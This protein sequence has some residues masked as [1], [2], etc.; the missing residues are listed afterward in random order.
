MDL[1]ATTSKQSGGEPRG[2]DSGARV[3]Y[4]EVDTGPFLLAGSWASNI[5]P[6]VITPFMLLLSYAVAREILQE[7]SVDSEM[8]D[9]RPPLLHELMRGAHGLCADNRLHATTQGTS[10]K[11]YNITTNYSQNDDPSY[12]AGLAA[13]E[14]LCN[15]TLT[16]P[17]PSNRSSALLP[18]SLNETDGLTNLALA[19]WTYLTLGKGI[20]QVTSNFS[21]VNFS[22][23]DKGEAKGTATRYEVVTHLDGDASHSLFFSPDAAREYDLTDL[24][25]GRNWG[26]DYVANTT[27]MVTECTFATEQCKITKADSG[28]ERAQGWNMSF[29]EMVDGSP[30][31]IPVQAQSNPFDFYAVTAVNSIDFP[32]FQDRNTQSEGGPDNNSLVDVGHG[33]IGFALDCHAT[34]YNVTYS[35]ID[36]SFR[37]FNA[38]KS[39]PQM[40]S[41]IKAPLQVGFGQYSLYQA[42]FLAVIADYPVNVTMAKAFSQT[43]MALASGVFDF[44]NNI[45]QRFR[46]TKTVTKVPKAPFYFLVVTCLLY[47]AFGMV[48]TAVAFYLRRTPEVREQQRRL[49]LEWSPELLEAKVAR[50][51]S[52]LR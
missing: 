39:S 11:I 20:S 21:N 3:Y 41:I 32:S 50:D 51:A 5:A 28:H 13:I 24:G 48:M 52:S 6:F 49:M 19:N 9:V 35:L 43:G 47:S 16:A 18:C 22:S 37:E 1:Q 42:A 44:D 23:S 45:Q 27:S 33:F 17:L 12:K 10:L 25:V 36:G 7:S 26:I 31:N 15:D 4:T 34:I 38:T 14:E 2:L 29:Y 46:W 8:S 40:A 30:S